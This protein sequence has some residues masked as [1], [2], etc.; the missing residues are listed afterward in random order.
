MSDYSIDIG[1][2]P[3]ATRGCTGSHMDPYPLQV[4]LAQGNLIQDQQSGLYTGFTPTA[5]ASFNQIVVGDKLIFRVFDTSPIWPAGERSLKDVRS[6]E[7]TC[8]GLLGD[9]LVIPWANNDEAPFFKASTAQPTLA[10]TSM[11]QQVTNL[12]CF[13]EMVADGTNGIVV[14]EISLS[15][16]QPGSTKTVLLLLFSIVIRAKLDSDPYNRT[17]YYQDDPEMVISSDEG[18]PPP[19]AATSL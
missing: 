14:H 6:L 11:S 12:P 15:L 18:Q 4:A 1:I 5:L 2:H 10:F 16:K 7:A 9:D 19:A 8:K 13:F 3:D 17:Y